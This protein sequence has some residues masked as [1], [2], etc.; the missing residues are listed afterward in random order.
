[1]TSIIQYVTDIAG[2]YGMDPVQP[3]IENNYAIT[4]CY[5]HVIYN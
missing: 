2:I 1:M 3:Q 5:I 4:F